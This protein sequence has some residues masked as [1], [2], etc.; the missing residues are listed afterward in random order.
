MSIFNSD[1]LNE[2]KKSFRIWY[3][4]SKD[5]AYGGYDWEWTKGAS[6]DGIL[7]EDNSL[8][9]T[10]AGIETKTKAYGLKVSREAPVE[11]KTVFQDETSKKWYIIT[12]DQPLHSPRMSAI[13]MKIFTC[14]EYDP[15][16]FDG[17]EN[18]GNAD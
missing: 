11:F 18:D 1:L 17:E 3:R 14:Q 10:V 7:T 4:V 13:N 6:F 5:D 9:A 16:D 2:Y 12:S 15:L 8:T